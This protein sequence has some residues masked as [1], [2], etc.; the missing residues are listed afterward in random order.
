M[1]G[2]NQRSKQQK[3][4]AVH[5][6]KYRAVYPS[7]LHQPKACED[8]REEKDQDETARWTRSGMLSPSG[9]PG[10]VCF[11]AETEDPWDEEKS[12][13]SHHFDFTEVNG[14]EQ[15]RTT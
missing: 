3:K 15:S 4:P 10:L 7:I 11:Q 13:P 5:E 8:S 9:P 12:I 1:E 2:F 6:L 14:L